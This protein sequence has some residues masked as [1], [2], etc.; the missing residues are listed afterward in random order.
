MAR[1]IEEAISYFKNNKKYHR[2]LKRIAEKYKSRGTLGGSIELKNL[3]ED[4]RAL[5]CKID[6][7]YIYAKDAKFT[8][9]KFLKT[10]DNV[11]I[12]E[13]DFLQILQ[14]YFSGEIQTN[15]EI[16]E[17]KGSE[18]D[19]Y[20]SNI[21]ESFQ[22]TSGAK[23]LIEALD[24][25]KY[26]YLLLIKEYEKDSVALKEVLVHVIKAINLLEYW[27]NKLTR[28][29]IFASNLTKDPHFFDIG[30]L[31]GNLFINGLAFLGKTKTPENAQEESELLYSFGILKDEISNYTT[32]SSVTAYTEE[33]LHEGILG[34]HK[35]SEPVQL[36][37]WNL[38]KIKEIHCN[39]NKIFVFEN[40]AVFSEVLERTLEIRPSLLCTSGQLKL[41]SLVFLDKLIKNID[42]IYYSGDFD[43]EGI[44]IAYRLKERYGDKLVLW[45]YDSEEYEKIKSKVS[46]EERRWKQIAS[47]EEP[48]LKRLVEQMEKD[49]VCG[50]QELLVE[51]Y[52]EDIRRIEKLLKL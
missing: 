49:R 45:R 26:G 44:K 24:S 3:T 32:I 4:E 22:G 29:P 41:A 13:L 2:I 19:K 48:Q 18:R 47:I 34:F 36:N 8:V 30:Q 50:Y 35:S 5:L 11:W 20:F 23:W 31:G 12:G 46:F 51:E 28:L 6:P 52:V 7:K 25:R 27:S 17:K 40:P 14:G 21:L 37:L 10:F 1:D 16:K 15:K 38:S 33:G 42:K 9:R 39:Y 43:P